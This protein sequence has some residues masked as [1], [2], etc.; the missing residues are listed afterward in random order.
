MSEASVSAKAYAKILLHAAKYPHL[1]VNGLLLSDKSDKSRS[2][3]IVD[4]IPMFHQCVHVTPMAEIA[5]IQA[6]AR[7]AK[8]N[9]QIAGYYA[10]AEN[11]YDNTLD[12]VP[13]LRVAEKVAEFNANAYLVLVDNRLVSMD[14]RQPALRLWQWN[15]TKWGVAK[16]SLHDQEETLGAVS[17][18][19]QDGAMKELVDFDNHLDNPEKFENPL[20]NVLQNQIEL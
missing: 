18:L 16:Y 17:S 5:L 1:A 13:G 9:L 6:E 19:L 20:T 14:M 3:A 2:P 10:A 15:E 12:R 11:F 7:A 8:E 4:A